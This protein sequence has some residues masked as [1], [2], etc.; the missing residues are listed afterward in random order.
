M[1][2][3]DSNN[4][5]LVQIMISVF[6]SIFLNQGDIR[7]VKENARKLF[8]YRRGKELLNSIDELYVVYHIARL[9]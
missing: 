9:N 3:N 8:F 2:E 6:E 1:K 4:I 7:D 5:L